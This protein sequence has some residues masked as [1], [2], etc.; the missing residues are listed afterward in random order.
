MAAVLHPDWLIPDWPAPA[1]VRAV[2]T[3]R[4]GGESAPPYDS[5]NL[6][7][8][9]GDSPDSVAANRAL[10]E[11][12]IGTQA[13][14]LSQVH[15]SAV[16]PLDAATPDGQTAD[17]CV[18]AQR[19]LAC[20][21]MVADCLPVLLATQDGRA[22]GAAHAGWRGLAGVGEDSGQGIL[23]AAHASLTMLGQTGR[24]PSTVKVKVKVMAWLGPCIGPDAFEV[25]PE[26]KAAF[27]ARQP[28]A[29]RLFVQIAA[30]K[31]LA[32]L[33]ALARLRL[34]ALGVEQVYGNDGSLPWCTVGNP[35]RFFSHRRDAGVN[36]NGRGTTGRMAA[37]IWLD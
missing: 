28:Q 5:L 14:F 11:R 37:C 30:G 32:N 35:S 6:G 16:L 25:G 1:G 33:P 29:G 15:G 22:V 4:A 21:V 23:E 12:A 34:Q 7:S 20:T 9:V 36:G 8:H 31:Y 10:L 24:A 26:V 27:E 17:G 2:F 19:R 18:T 13:V 3:T